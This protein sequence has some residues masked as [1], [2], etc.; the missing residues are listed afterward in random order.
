MTVQPHYPNWPTSL[1]GP[2]K[3]QPPPNMRSINALR[4][5]QFA[6]INYDQMTGEPA[7]ADPPRYHPGQAMEG[8][9]SFDQP[10]NDV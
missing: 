8:R 7:E 9:T 6:E 10:T 2:F 4:S 1:P 5:E 3:M